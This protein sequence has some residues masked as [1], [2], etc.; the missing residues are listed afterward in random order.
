MLPSCHLHKIVFL[1]LKVFSFKNNELSNSASIG[2]SG[3][4]Q[5]LSDGRDNHKPQRK[6]VLI[7][8]GDDQVAPEHLAQVS[9]NK[10]SPTVG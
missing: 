7:S 1:E 4:R 10:G 8:V 2:I 6:V 5:E 9:A 3:Q